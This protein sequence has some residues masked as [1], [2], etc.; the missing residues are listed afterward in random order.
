MQSA[1]VLT[2]MGAFEDP[3]L[4]EISAS[5]E[6][7]GRGELSEKAALDLIAR[8]VRRRVEAPTEIY[9]KPLG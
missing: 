9:Q 3:D 7:A 2:R 8:V 6:Q 1:D 5:I 4:R